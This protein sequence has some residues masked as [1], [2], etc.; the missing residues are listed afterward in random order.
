MICTVLVVWRSYET[1]CA[2]RGLGVG[3]WNGLIRFIYDIAMVESTRG[4]DLMYVGIYTASYGLTRY[5]TVL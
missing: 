2:L 4:V 5:I 3:F 1:M